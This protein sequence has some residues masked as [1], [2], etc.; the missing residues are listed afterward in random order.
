MADR[1]ATLEETLEKI[2]LTAEWEKRG[3]AR[4]VVI[5]EAQGEAR[6]KK[7]AWQEVIELLKQG[8]T[9]EELERMS[10]QP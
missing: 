2:G 3:E 4:G 5:G 9:V 1:K 8:R 6:G 7:L 10:L